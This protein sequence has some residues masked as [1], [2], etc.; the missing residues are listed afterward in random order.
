MLTVDV[1][2][3]TTYGTSAAVAADRFTSLLMPTA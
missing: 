3:T 1:R 2:L